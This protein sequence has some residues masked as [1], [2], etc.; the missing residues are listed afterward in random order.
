MDSSPLVADDV[1]LARVVLSACAQPA[2]VNPAERLIISAARC[3]RA[4]TSPRSRAP[5]SYSLAE[6]FFRGR[7]LYET[8]RA[9]RTMDV[10]LYPTT[11]GRISSAEYVTQL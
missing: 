9:G 6:V 10:F 1:R 8:G 2:S 7:P 11:Y 3:V 4:E 5:R